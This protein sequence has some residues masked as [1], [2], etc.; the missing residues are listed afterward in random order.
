MNTAHRGWTRHDDAMHDP[1]RNRTGVWLAGAL[2]FLLAFGFIN[3]A[4]QAQKDIGVEG[5]SFSIVETG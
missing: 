1:P 3:G 5:E 2:A 4:V